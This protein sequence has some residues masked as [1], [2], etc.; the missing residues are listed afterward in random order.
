M[1]KICAFSCTF[2]AKSRR[3]SFL[4]A[5]ISPRRLYGLIFEQQ[6]LY[7]L[8]K[9]SVLLDDTLPEPALL[10]ALQYPGGGEVLLRGH[11]HYQCIRNI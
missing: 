9:I 5:Y 3:Q 8:I 2:I 11:P 7:V 4:C 6:R 1:P 10:G